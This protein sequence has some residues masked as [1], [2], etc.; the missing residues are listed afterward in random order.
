MKNTEI[1]FSLN[2]F[3]CASEVIEI[4]LK[5]FVFFP[6]TWS[7]KLLNTSKPK[8]F[9]F[10]ISSVTFHTY[11]DMGKDD[12]DDYNDGEPSDEDCYE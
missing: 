7:I 4:Q 3:R 6:S 8:P 1:G 11:L 12:G 10:A 2:I 9:F 5:N